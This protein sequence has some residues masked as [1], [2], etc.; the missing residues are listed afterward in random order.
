ME[1]GGWRS[2]KFAR[3]YAVGGTANALHA[4]DE[5]AKQFVESSRFFQSAES[6]MDG[7]SAMGSWG[8]PVIALLSLLPVAFTM[9]LGFRRRKDDNA[10]LDSLNQT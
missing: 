5:A 8:F 4:N 2:R 6:I 9:L 7:L 1:G 10:A 3:D